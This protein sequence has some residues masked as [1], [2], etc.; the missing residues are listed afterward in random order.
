M[1]QVSLDSLSDRDAKGVRRE[2]GMVVVIQIAYTNTHDS[3][4]LGLKITPFSEPPPPTYTYRVFTTAASSYMLTKTSNDPGDAERII[5]VYNGIRIL[6]EQSGSI[7]TFSMA[8]FLVVFSSALGLLAISTTLTE[9]I[10]LQLMPRKDYY[11]ARKYAQTK[12]LHT[13]D[14][15]EGRRVSDADQRRIDVVDRFLEAVDTSDAANVYETMEELLNE[16]NKA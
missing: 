12:D 5:R 14:N 3:A 6:V 7:A 15:P 8:T 13:E 16:I 4:W 11:N 1:A 10:M 9:I 2:S